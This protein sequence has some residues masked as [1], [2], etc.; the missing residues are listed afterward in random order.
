MNC[1]MLASY[2]NLP[3]C[4]VQDHISYSPRTALD[5]CVELPQ[6][7]SKYCCRRFSSKNFRSIDTKKMSQT[8]MAARLRKTHCYAF[9]SDTWRD[10][11]RSL[12]HMHY[13]IFQMLV[14]KVTSSHP[15][16]D[17]QHA[18]PISTNSRCISSRNHHSCTFLPMHLE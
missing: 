10:H 14:A 4:F 9:H 18:I 16:P 17:M 7:L 8:C 3:R 1:K 11:T 5:S 12:F 13:N 15:T 2:S 6:C